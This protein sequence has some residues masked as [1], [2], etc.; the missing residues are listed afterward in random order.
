HH[1]IAIL[2]D[3]ALVVLLQGA[4]TLGVLVGRVD[5]VG[6]H[7]VVHEDHDVVAVHDDLL[8]P[9]GVVGYEL[10]EHLRHSVQAAGA[11]RIG[12]GV[13]H[14]R[15]RALGKSGTELGAGVHARIAA[16]V[17]L[18]FRAAPA[19]AALADHPEEVAA[20]AVADDGAVDDL[21]AFGIVS[22][23]PALKRLAVEHADPAVFARDGAGLI[24]A[25]P[26]DGDGQRQDG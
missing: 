16:V 19:V 18:H 2:H 15:L 8:R 1:Q 26:G 22:G 23:F 3:A 12:R 5:I 25:H 6:H 14:L 13:F 7:F 9:P 24:G 4:V 10:F 21:P 17:Q 11:L 20:H